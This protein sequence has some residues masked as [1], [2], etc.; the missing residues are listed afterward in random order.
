MPSTAGA[1]AP[2]ADT[3]Q[4]PSPRTEVVANTAVDPVRRAALPKSLR[5]S[6]IVDEPAVIELYALLEG[7]LSS[8]DKDLLAS[9]SPQI[10]RDRTRG[11]G[12]AQL[13]AI[14]YRAYD[15]DQGGDLRDWLEAAG[16]GRFTKLTPIP[17][18]AAPGQPLVRAEFSIAAALHI[19]TGSRHGK[20]AALRTR[21][22][23]PLI[24][25]TTWK[26][27]V[28]A[29]AGYILRSCWG[30]NAACTSQLGCSQCPLCGLFGSTARRGRISFRDS[31]VIA[32]RTQARTHVA[33]DRISGGGK[34]KLLF[35]DNVVSSGTVTL[36]IFAL[37][38]VAAWEHNLL[39][40]VVRDIH[41]G[42]I[43]IGSGA[44]RGQ[45]TLKLTDDAHPAVTG[46]QPMPD[47]PSD[48]E[49]VT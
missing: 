30:D 48:K 2:E 4:P 39:L 49:A 7:E 36:T 9:W 46:L 14:G 1:D 13:R 47:Q 42:L 15:L 28:R 21:G 31:T 32:P 24:P 29:R 25:A 16:P 41:D 11:G 18:T 43:G 44:Q 34:D 19:G 12:L 10:G 6:R 17:I 27:L 37:G 22:G 3:E 23:Q 20:N 45:G 5:H 8:A 38:P 40:H 33:I 26:G 35:T